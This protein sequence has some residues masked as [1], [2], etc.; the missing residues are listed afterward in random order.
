MQLQVEIGFN[1]LSLNCQILKPSSYH[2]QPQHGKQ[3]PN[4]MSSHSKTRI[5][6]TQHLHSR[7]VECVEFLGGAESTA[8]PFFF[9]VSD[10]IYCVTT[11][12]LLRICL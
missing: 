5:R 7:F 2:V 8:K 4:T 9:G 3:A 11:H 10:F 1:S 6:W 12:Q